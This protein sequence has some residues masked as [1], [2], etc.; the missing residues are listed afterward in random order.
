MDVAVGR[1]HLRGGEVKRVVVVGASA[2]GLG[3]AEALRRSGYQGVITLVGD[4]PHLPYD[5]PPLSKQL[6]KGA[7]QP[8]RLELRPTADIDA[9]I[10]DKVAFEEV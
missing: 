3:T 7:W 8:D 5:R 9:L 4:E 10:G 1:G 2:G 6:L